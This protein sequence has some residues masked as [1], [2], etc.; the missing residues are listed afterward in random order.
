MTSVVLHS[1]IANTSRRLLIRKLVGSFFRFPLL[2]ILL[3][4]L[5]SGQVII[6][7]RPL[8]RRIPSKQWRQKLC[9][10]GSVFGS[11]NV[12]IHT[13]Q[14]TS[15]WRL[16][17]K[18]FISMIKCGTRNGLR[19]ENALNWEV[20]WSNVSF[21]NPRTLT[22]HKV[23]LYMFWPLVY[24]R[25]II[26]SERQS[27]LGPDY[28]A[29]FS[30]VSGTNSQEIKLAITWRMTQPGPQFSPGWKSY[31]VLKNRARI[32]SPAQTG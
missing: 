14:D 20:L 4:L 7:W 19:I 28:M 15:S 2:G 12:V 26:I 16:F 9:K 29:N 23:K 30:P 18:V 27:F 21:I 8:V 1:L 5:H 24:F 13:E 3:S 11:V 6:S 10:H 22:N 31:P 17:S 32:F 25:G